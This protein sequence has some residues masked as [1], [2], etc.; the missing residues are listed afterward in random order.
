MKKRYIRWS[1]KFTYY[2]EDWVD[3]L[4]IEWPPVDDEKALRFI[5]NYSSDKLIDIIW[6]HIWKDKGKYNREWTFRFSNSKDE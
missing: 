3:Y 5:W 6:K 1:Y 2:T 4:D